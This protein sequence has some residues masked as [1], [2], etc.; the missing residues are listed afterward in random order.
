MDY[1]KPSLQLSGEDGNIFSIV[2]RARRVMR[3][4][5]IPN[6]VIEEMSNKVMASGSYDEALR[7]VM[8]YCDVD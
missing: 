7:V 3:R 5:E 2:G 6:S 1:P 8:G 4:A